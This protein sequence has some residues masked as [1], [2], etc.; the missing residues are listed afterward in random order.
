[1]PMPVKYRFRSPEAVDGGRLWALA[2]ET[3]LDLN[4]PYCYLMLG[5]YFS[6]T[7]LVAEAEFT[8]S[9]SSD[10]QTDTAR[11]GTGEP[12]LAGFVLGF[13]PP[14]R[15]DTLFIWQICVL[16]SARGHGLASSL[17]QKLL[18]TPAC[19][20]VRYLEATVTPSNHASHALFAGQARKLGVP[21][22]VKECFPADWFPGGAHET[23]Q[24]YR[25]GPFSLEDSTPMDPA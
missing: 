25:I 19:R 14:A 13:R 18:R 15:Q 17:I 1:M 3:G 24:L 21:Y 23:E 2:K 10:A 5:H 22:V 8:P 4:S 7:C 16:P 6:D 20:G 11:N 9:R 12:S